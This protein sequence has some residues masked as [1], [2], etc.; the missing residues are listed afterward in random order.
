MKTVMQDGVGSVSVQEKNNGNDTVTN[1]KKH[2]KGY[3]HS[4]ELI[5]KRACIIALAVLVITQ[6]VLAMPSVRTA[7]F[8]EGAD[9]D[10][11]GSEAYI[12]VPCKLEM[13]LTDMDECSELKILVNGE[14]VGSFEGKSVLL[15]LKDGDIVEL[16]ASEVLVTPIVRISAAS[17]NIEYLLGKTVN[18]VGGIVPVAT[19]KAG[20]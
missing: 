10:P 4:I 2:S 15:E 17:R 9:G 19:L 8:N 6:A 12:F 7:F 14:A 16:D 5:L 20:N 13:S 1:V 3:L 11:L 18:A